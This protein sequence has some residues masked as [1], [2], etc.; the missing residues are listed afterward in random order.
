MWTFRPDGWAPGGPLVVVQH[1][2]GRNGWDYRDFW[3]EPAERH[4]LLVVTPTFSNEAWPTHDAYNN[5]LVR[6]EE[7]QVRPASSWTYAILLRILTALAERASI[8]PGEASLYGHSAG[9][10]FVHRFLTTQRTMPFARIT[11]ANAGWYTL[12]TLEAD[13]P[14]GLGGV[15]LGEEDLAR[16]L[17][18]PLTI[19]AGEEDNAT[20]DTNLPHNPEA[21]AQGP[22]RFARA[23]TYYDAGKAEAKRRGLPF[24]WQLVPVPGIGHDGDAMSK[25]AASLW[26]DGT[27]PD[28]TQ[29]AGRHAL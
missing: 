18:F 21:L 15:G 22:H 19:L 4:G 27:M 25:V 23:H 14:A 16:L 20:N 24:G 10:Q 9:G 6:D 28:L 5:G 1:G 11:A 29:L 2:M 8:R 17:A 12:P 3:I 7:G 13:F 26:F